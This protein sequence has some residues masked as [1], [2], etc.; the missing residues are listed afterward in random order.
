M[1]SLVTV[2]C[3]LGAIIMSAACSPTKGSGRI[4]AVGVY[5]LPPAGL[6]LAVSVDAEGIVHYRVTDSPG[7]KILENSDRA[8][9]YQ[10]WFFIWGQDTQRLWFMSS[11]IGIFLHRRKAD[12]SFDRTVLTDA[13]SAEIREMPATVFEAQPKSLQQRWAG[14]R[15]TSK[16]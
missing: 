2:L 11:D 13:T 8:S 15:A 7:R 5:Q 6:A 16:P 12:G 1:R 3:L 4:D 14:I 10:R 9:T